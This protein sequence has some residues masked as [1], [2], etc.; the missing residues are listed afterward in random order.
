MFRCC[1]RPKLMKRTISH[2]DI[3]L[4]YKTPTPDCAIPYIPLRAGYVKNSGRGFQ[5]AALNVKQ[6]AHIWD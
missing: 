1:T 6:L 4:R 3:Q 2:R 5:E